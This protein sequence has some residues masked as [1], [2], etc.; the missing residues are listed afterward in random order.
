MEKVICI[1]GGGAA[2][3]A[4]LDGF[5]RKLK[6]KEGSG[7]TIYVVEKN[8]AFG[9]GA[10]YYDDIGSNLLNT[11]TGF[12]TIFPERKGDFHD[13]L[14]NHPE[15]WQWKYP[16]FD[17]SHDT[18][19]PRPLFGQYLQSAFS[20]TVS[21]AVKNGMKVVPVNAE[22]MDV[23]KHRE[24]YSVETACSISIHADYVF[25]MCGTLENARQDTPKMAAGVISNPYPVSKLTSWLGKDKDV[26]IIG[27]RLSA[28]D[29]IIALKE[30][31]H[32]GKIVMH[33]RSGYFPSV[34]GTQGRFSPRNLTQENINNIRSKKSSLSL[35]EVV[36][37]V[38]DDLELYFRDHPDDPQEPLA[39][40]API[41]NFGTFLSEEIA[42]A[43][44]PRG[45]QAVLYATNAI[46]DDLWGLI[47]D[48]DKEVF[49]ERYLS[50]FLSYRVSIPREN[51]IKIKKYFDEGALEFKSGP[52]RVEKN[53]NGFPV[54]INKM[55]NE[56]VFDFVVL[57]TGSPKRLSKSNSKLMTNL[58]KKGL[59]SSHPHGGL[60]VAG[61][62]YQVI[63]EDGKPENG[64]FAV[65]EVTS[66]K[67]FFTSALDIICRHAQR[68]AVSFYEDS[69][70]SEAISYR[71]DGAR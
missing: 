6:G 23:K 13:W 57:A 20:K 40:P 54:V 19:A 2:S 26:A 16:N 58:E 59:I 17:A 69:H 62:T 43:E 1:V 33:S 4:F 18:Y 60:E 49:R 38:R 63:R 66:G 39:L 68:A 47:R 11:K 52:V 64:L 21:N 46:I 8:P 12:I 36:D 56:E 65:G 31:G 34:R 10:A 41:E 3:I 25:L 37:M 48:E 35:R 9:P 27:S 71:A 50:I 7:Y 44:G 22:V 28:I 14:H 42:L 67:F 32:L 53:E 45:W 24:G 55:S 30:A 61:D 29:T 51:A 70:E 15:H 5:M